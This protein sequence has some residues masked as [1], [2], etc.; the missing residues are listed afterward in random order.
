MMD[1]GSLIITA[2]LIPE[3]QE[4]NDGVKL[5]KGIMD[6]RWLLVKSEKQNKGKVNNFNVILKIDSQRRDEEL[7]EQEIDLFILQGELTDENDEVDDVLFVGLE[8][9]DEIDCALSGL[10]TCW[11]VITIGDKGKRKEMTEAC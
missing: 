4:G 2:G 3:A 1:E 6:D 9:L 5:F 7:K 8:L 10:I 11:K